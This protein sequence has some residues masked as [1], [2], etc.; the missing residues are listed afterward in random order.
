MIKSRHPA[1][2]G[3]LKCGDDLPPDGALPGE[4]WHPHTLTAPSP[5]WRLPLEPTHCYEQRR[6]H[7]NVRAITKRC[8]AGRKEKGSS[9]HEPE[10][11]SKDGPSL[12]GARKAPTPTVGL[13]RKPVLAR[14]DSCFPWPK[15][16]PLQRL[17]F[18]RAHFK[19]A[20]EGNGCEPWPSSL[21][22]RRPLATSL[23]YKGQRTV[24]AKIDHADAMWQH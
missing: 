10:V 2:A 8:H 11:R 12:P 23:F 16:L 7:G 6:E 18:A 9:D 5:P 22:A 14:H 19:R 1:D 15:K 4:H 20:L 24:L 13:G 17:G 21:R 3:G